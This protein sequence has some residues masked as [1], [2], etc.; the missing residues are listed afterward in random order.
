MRSPTA[1]DADAG[2]LHAE[3]RELAALA[4]ECTG[5]GPR[6]PLPASVLHTL[7]VELTVLV[8]LGDDARIDWLATEATRLLADAG[9]RDAVSALGATLSRLRVAP[10]ALPARRA[11]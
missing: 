6:R 8:A 1:I 2:F 7:S 4:E 5:R 9:K 11:G 10:V 3:A